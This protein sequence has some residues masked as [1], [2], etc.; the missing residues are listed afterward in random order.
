MTSF[1][2]CFLLQTL[3]DEESLAEPCSATFMDLV[4]TP[5][6]RKHTFILSFNW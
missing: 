1:G 5:K 6:M 3:K 2:L 4:R